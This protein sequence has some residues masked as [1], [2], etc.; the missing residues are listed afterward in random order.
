M[1]ATMEAWAFRSA[2][3][4]SRWVAG[5]RAVIAWERSRN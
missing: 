4:A 2:R 3:Q 1:R 5:I